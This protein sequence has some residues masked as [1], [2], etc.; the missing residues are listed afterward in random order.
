MASLK[1]FDRSQIEEY[2]WLI[3]VDEAGRGA[4]AGPVVAGAVVI[5]KN[6]LFS[7][8]GLR[9][10]SQVNDS[11]A[12]QEPL[13][14]SLLEGMERRKDPKQFAF[15]TGMASVPEIEQLNIL[16]ATR[17]AMLRALVT[18]E[19]RNRGG[20]RLARVEEQGLWGASSHPGASA[21]VLVDGR[22]LK[23][24]PFVHTGLVKG[25][26]RSLAIAMASVAAKVTRDRIMRVAEQ[27]YPK[28]HFG[29]HKGYGTPSHLNCLKQFGPT[30]AHRS[31]FLKKIL[32]PVSKDSPVIS[33]QNLTLI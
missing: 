19:A 6:L 9:W 24:F 30:P 23:P 32:H 11:K 26:A 5:S 21:R 20:W 8:T 10:T 4:L 13:R 12:L 3:G 18:L 1:H 15:A 28:F 17:L 27:S 22:P 29:G 16:G 25:D 7:R 2:A 33:P 14:E 31:S